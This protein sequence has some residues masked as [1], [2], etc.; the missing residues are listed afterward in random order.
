[1]PIP[2]SIEKPPGVGN[3]PTLL[4]SPFKFHKRGQC[5]MG[6]S[7]LLPQLST[8]ADDVTLVRSMHTG[9]NNHPEAM[10]IQMGNNGPL[11][12]SEMEAIQKATADV[13]EL[14]L[15]TDHAPVSWIGESN[16]ALEEAAEGEVAGARLARISGRR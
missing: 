6:L 14:F 16:G 10:I 11:Y 8:I 5:G 7:E 3:A 12:G 1:M 15:I 2:L 9:N 4:A 13:G